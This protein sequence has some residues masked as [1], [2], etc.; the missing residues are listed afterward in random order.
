MCELTRIFSHLLAAFQHRNQICNRQKASQAVYKAKPH[1]SL[2]EEATYL[3]DTVKPGVPVLVGLLGWGS[4]PPV[5][6]S[7]RIIV[8]S[9]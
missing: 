7:S 3:C 2:A 1:T 4:G 8:F 5:Y 9:M 6:Q